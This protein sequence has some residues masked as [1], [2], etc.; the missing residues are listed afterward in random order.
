MTILLTRVDYGRG[1]GTAEL[2]AVSSAQPVNQNGPRGIVL[3]RN[4][5]PAL[6]RPRYRA[7]G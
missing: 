3:E 4:Q 7:I 1:F 2:Y 6:I 5:E